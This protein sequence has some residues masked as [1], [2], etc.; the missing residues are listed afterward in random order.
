M[1]GEAQAKEKRLQ[2]RP[3]SPE[4]RPVQQLAMQGVLQVKLLARK[5]ERQAT[6]SLPKRPPHPNL[7]EAPKAPALEPRNSRAVPDNSAED[8]TRLATR[9]LKA[10]AMEPR[11]SILSN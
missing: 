6:T 4:Q 1:P 8:A 3:E 5:E 7:P 9:A 10:S 11:L 2:Q